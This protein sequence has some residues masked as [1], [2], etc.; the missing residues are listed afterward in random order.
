MWLVGKTEAP[1]LQAFKTE[2]YLRAL[3]FLPFVIPVVTPGGAIPDGVAVGLFMLSYAF[4]QR[5]RT[6]VGA[7]IAVCVFPTVVDDAFM[8]TGSGFKLIRDGAE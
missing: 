4:V 8:N 7:K 5:E 1:R 3:M 6:G 2:D